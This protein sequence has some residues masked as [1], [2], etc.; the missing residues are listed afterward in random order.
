[1]VTR[2]IILIFFISSFFGLKAQVFYG[3][4]FPEFAISTKLGKGYK[5]T[6]KVE[7]M[8]GLLFKS[9]DIQSEWDYFHDRTDVQMFISNK[10]TPF[11][12]LT[13]GGQYRIEEGVN[14]FRSIQQIS[15]L[16]LKDNLRLGHRIRADQTFHPDA[17]DQYRIRYRFSLEKPLQGLDLNPGEIYL[18]ISD[19]LIY[20][21][22]PDDSD[23]ENRLNIALGYLLNSANKFQIGIDF[24]TDKIIASGSRNRAWLKMGWY[25]NI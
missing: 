5:Y 16:V 17:P 6:T 7:S 15:F 25:T 23:M 22:E 21:Y 11:K 3:G 20:S 12:N 24:R 2:S 1:M 19:E 14:T 13:F 9:A 10:L 8:H 4:M 18:I